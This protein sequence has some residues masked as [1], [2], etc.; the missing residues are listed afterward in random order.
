MSIML[1]P[2]KQPLI[3]RK[4]IK[5]NKLIR[6]VADRL[7]LNFTRYIRDYMLFYLARIVRDRDLGRFDVGCRLTH[8]K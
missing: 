8:P 3:I 5:E 6:R 2:K 7:F 4:K 1:S